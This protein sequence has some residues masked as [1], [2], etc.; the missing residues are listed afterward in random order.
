M[1]EA[2][3]RQ[4]PLAHLHLEARTNND[5]DGPDAGVNVSEFT[6]RVQI[7]L[8][9][10][11]SDKVF[12]AA[13]ENVLS[14]SL[15]AAPCT[16][17]GDASGLHVLWMGPDEWLVVAPADGGH[18]TLAQDLTVA[19]TATHAA[20]VDVSESRTTIHINGRDAR[21]TLS[22][23][24]SIDLH[25]RNFAKGKVVNTLLAQAHVTLHQVSED[26][27]DGGC[28]YDLFVHRSFAEYLWSW[29]E[30][31]TREYGLNIS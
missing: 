22:K 21:G 7:A 16:S 25:P 20:V 9:G 5:S 31:A 24:C 1:V 19:L 27:E 6:H 10:S 11:T 23:G 15:P 28:A 12:T 13:V 26:V 14:V 29:L 30:D 17:A 4:S 2:Y 18:E 8:R 3:L